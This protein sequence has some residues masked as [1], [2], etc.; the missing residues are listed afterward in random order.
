MKETVMKTSL[1]RRRSAALLTLCTFALASCG[2]SDAGRDASDT[3]AAA[4]AGTG[5]AASPGGGPRAYVSN[6]DSNNITVIDTN[7]D[8]VIA[9]IPVGKRPRG[10]EVG[11]KGEN[12]YVAV[13]GT[14]KAPPGTDEDTLPPPDTTAD[15]IAVVSVASGQVTT[16]FK[17]GSDPEEF[18][19]SP[20]G[21]SIYVSNED[22]GLASVVDVESG[23]VTEQIKV[24]VEPEGVG[25]SPDGKIVYVTGETNHDITVIDTEA[26]KAVETFKVGERPRVAIF[27]KDGSRAYISS[28]IGGTVTVVDAKTHKPITTI[29]LPKG[30]RPMGLALSPDESQLWVANGRGK[31]VSVINTATNEIVKT[32]E[33]VGERPWGIAITPD[34]KKVYTANGPSDNVTVIDATAMKVIKQIPAGDGPWGVDISEPTE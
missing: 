24:G 11:P 30:S 7:T 10:I 12:I 1:S 34:G 19:I 8:S 18:A 31:T 3:T 27:K 2:P 29:K 28:E 6:E 33:G 26:K 14:P 16:T 17:S 9:T 21:E 4:P 23:K 5:E 22:A 32:I 20:G 25:I 15:G 13:S